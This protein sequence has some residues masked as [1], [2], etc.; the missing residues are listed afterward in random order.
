MK[1]LN[2]GSAVRGTD[3]RLA[4]SERHGASDRV[5]SGVSSRKERQ[6]EGHDIN[7]FSESDQSQLFDDPRVADDDQMTDRVQ[8]D[9]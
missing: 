1:L 4:A 6:S 9:S 8:D 3:D 7:E 2:I 5:A